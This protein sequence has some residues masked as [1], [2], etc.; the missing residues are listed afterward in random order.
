MAAASE[1]TLIKFV[2]DRPGHDLRYSIDFKRINTDLGWQPSFDFDK[3]LENTVDWYLNNKLTHQY[4][5]I[6]IEH[7]NN[8]WITAIKAGYEVA[9]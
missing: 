2:E 4:K 7:A 8:L 3:S 9:F 1:T 6:T 5:D